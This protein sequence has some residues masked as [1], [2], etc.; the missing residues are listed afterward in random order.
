MNLMQKTAYCFDLDGTVTLKEI[1]PELAREADLLEEIQL[2]TDATLKGVIPFEKSLRLRYKLLSDLGLSTI[3]KIISRIPLQPDIQNFITTHE[4]QCFIVTGN[5]DIW[6]QPVIEILK[7][8]VYSSRTNFEKNSYQL[9][10]VLNKAEAIHKIRQNFERVIAI[11]DS[12]NDVSM[13]EASDIG[14]AYGGVHST[15]PSLLDVSHY[16]VTNGKG[17]CRLLNML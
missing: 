1:L 10:H 5:L 16:V 6:I 9:S 8:K 15:V 4:S 14:I 7:C 13:F 3:Q 17:L 2:L 11:G 12:M